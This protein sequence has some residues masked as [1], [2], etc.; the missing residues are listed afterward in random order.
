MQKYDLSFIKNQLLAL[1][2]KKGDLI[3]L[4]VSF[5][6]LR[7]INEGPKKIIDCILEIIG[8]DGSLIAP[9]YTKAYPIWAVYAGLKPEFDVKNTKSY[10]GGLAEILMNE[11]HAIRSTHPTNSMVGIGRFAKKILSEH[12]PTSGAYS[13]YSKLA[14]NNGFLLNIGIGDSL[15]GLRHE[16][17]SICGLLRI[18]Q[19]R[20]AVK[21]RTQN[22]DIKIFRRHDTG[23]CVKK[24]N[25]ITNEMRKLNLINDGV[26]ADSDALFVNASIALNFIV[27]KLSSKPELYLCEE[28]NCL[29]CRKI[30]KY[31]YSINAR[32][33]SEY[34]KIGLIR[35][36][37]NKIIHIFRCYI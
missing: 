10:T 8:S 19:C 22:G 24:M 4:S 7:R 30:D 20:R 23:G 12:K 17:Q 18:Y 21:Y 15:V 16:A 9:A 36:F 34:L 37:F 3:S 27:D 35:I 25:N 26:V 6:K 32:T 14:A 31:L 29:F 13:P 1:G 5:K 11:Y 28:H 2:L 33:S